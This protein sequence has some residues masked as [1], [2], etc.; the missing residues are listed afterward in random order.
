MLAGSSSFYETNL[1]RN[2]I[3]GQV[4]LHLL[5]VLLN[6]Y[7]TRVWKRFNQSA[8]V[9]YLLRVQ[10]PFLGCQVPNFNNPIYFGYCFILYVL[11][12]PC[13]GIEANL[14][15]VPFLHICCVDDVTIS[16][17]SHLYASRLFIQSLCVSFHCFHHLFSLK[18]VRKLS[19]NQCCFCVSL[20]FGCYSVNIHPFCLVSLK[21]FIN[22]R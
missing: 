20:R 2:D 5:C 15:R 7:F 9:T 18:E 19:F 13:F 4:R 1:F 3:F 14:H 11:N 16:P 12:S 8:V 10:F 21:S 17:T 22:F 6:I